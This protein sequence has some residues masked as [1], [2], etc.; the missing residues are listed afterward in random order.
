M[1]VKDVKDYYFKM[2][3]QFFEMKAD[4]EDFEEALKNGFITEEQLD[5]VKNDVYKIELNY[6]RLLFIMYLLELPNRPAKK[7]KYRNSPQNKALENYFDQ[8][9]A[10]MTQV[11][12]E[13]KSLLTSIR[14]HLK[15]LAKQKKEEL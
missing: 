9:N 13:N 8:T 12:D 14:A 15:Q 3:K 1:A 6:Q 4:L 2:Q 10:S 5:A 7:V 11:V